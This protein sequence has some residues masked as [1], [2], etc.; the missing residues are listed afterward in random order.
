MQ[1]LEQEAVMNYVEVDVQ[2]CDGDF[3]EDEDY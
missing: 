3:E 1:E 2:V